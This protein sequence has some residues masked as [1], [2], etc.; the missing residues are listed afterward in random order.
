MR[1][2]ASF[3]GQRHRRAYRKRRPTGCPAVA[4]RFRRA[5]R[6]TLRNGTSN[7]HTSNRFSFAEL[8]DPPA[9]AEAKPS[10]C[11]FT[12][13][14]AGAVLPVI[15]FIAGTSIFGHRS[16]SLSGY[17]GL[18]LSLDGSLPLMP[19]LLICMGSIIVLALR[20]EDAENG[21]VRLG[22][23]SGVVLSLEYWFIFQVAISN[24]NAW[25]MLSCI[26]RGV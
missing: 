22:V 18:L 8:A 1:L 2:V 3:K 20:P 14:F 16:Q 21:W 15:C 10:G 24:E 23:F 7:R 19:L 17:A 26:L 12:W 11:A 25:S 6:H 4:L 13:V 5:S 9:D